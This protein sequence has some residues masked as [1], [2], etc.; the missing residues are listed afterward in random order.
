VSER[1]AF[2]S[3]YSA[4]GS[5]VGCARRILL[6]LRQTGWQVLVI[7]T[8]LNAEAQAWCEAEGVEW[9]LRANQ[10]RDFGAFQAAWQQFE[11]QGRWQDCD[12]LILLNDSVYLRRDR[13]QTSWPLF[14]KGVE[15]VVLGFTDSFQNGYHLQSYALHV[16]AIVL[17]SSAWSEFWAGLDTSRG[18]ASII[19][20]GEIGLS[21]Q[22]LKAGFQLRALHPLLHLRRLSASGHFSDWLSGQLDS[23]HRRMAKEYLQSLGRITACL[24]NPSHQ[25]LFPLLCDGVP[26][27]KRDVLEAN[28]SAVPDPFLLAGGEQWFDADEL[29]AYLKPPLLGFK[30]SSFL[31]KSLRVL[32]NLSIRAQR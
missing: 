2:F 31:Q 25:L 21:S 15:D 10:G 1:F 4:A 8:A 26:L 5:L 17:R 28:G 11:R 30:G 24:L 20:D 19:R 14:L 23:G 27:I 13:Q 9:L 32:Y 7:S 12:G 22:L 3:H 6:S 18:T 29:V 16:P